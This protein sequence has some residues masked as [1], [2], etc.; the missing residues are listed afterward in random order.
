MRKRNMCCAFLRSVAGLAIVWFASCSTVLAQGGGNNNNNNNAPPIA[1]IDIDASGVLSIKQIDPELMAEQRK[2]AIRSRKGKT[3]SSTMRKVSLNRLEQAIANKLVNSENLSQEMYAVAGLTRIE[4]VFYFPGSKDIV[5]AGPAEDVGYD[6]QTDRLVGA[7]SQRPTLRLDDLLVALRTF[8]PDAKRGSFIGCSIDPTPEGLVRYQQFYAQLGGN[9]GS[10]DVMEIARG[11]RDSLGLQTISVYGVPSNTHFAR[12]LVEADYRMKL[13]GIGL[14]KPI[15][16]L[17]SWVDRVRPGGATNAMQRWFFVADY[18]KVSVSPDGTALKFEGQGVKLVGEDE[19]VD[20][21][22][23]RVVTGKVDKA[24]T[25]YTSEFTKKFEQIAENSPIFAEMR[26]LYD[27]SVAAAYIQEQ[28]FYS[29]SGWSL[30]AM[31]QEST[32]PVERFS[33][34]KHV[35]P[36]V[37]A[38]RAGSTFMWPIGGGVEISAKRILSP[39]SRVQDQE[40]GNTKNNASVPANLAADQ[41]W[42]D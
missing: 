11:F 31:A 22:G 10:A 23:N 42:W 5:I 37:N 41:W 4:Y 12:T 39:E 40:L 1:G 24:S 20:A 17:K 6:P 2:A 29:Q 32:L 16:T 38:V 7:A 25:A 33:S 34:P 9:L 28:D 13:I 26:N 8:G 3:T 21:N 14:E 27:L 18:S 30:G 36:A 35:E 19:R 15:K